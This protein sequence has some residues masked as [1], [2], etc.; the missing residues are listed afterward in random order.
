MIEE[1]TGEKRIDCR[2]VQETMRAFA[3]LMMHPLRTWP[4]NS[5]TFRCVQVIDLR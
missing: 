1:D 4:S 5:P 3:F 2:R